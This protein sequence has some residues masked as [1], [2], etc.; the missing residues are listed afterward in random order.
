MAGDFNIRD[1]LWNSSFPYHSSI[2]N[3][4]IIIADSFHLSLLSSINQV[5]TR[6]AD[7]S[8]DANS[9]IDLMFL[10][11]DSSE[12]NNHFIHPKWCLSSDHAPLIIMIPIAEEIINM[13]K[14]TISKDS[15]EDESFIKDV[16]SSTKNLDVLKLLDIPSLEKAVNNLAKDIDNAWTKNSKLT[17]ITKHSKSWWNN[18]CNRNLKRYRS[19]KSLED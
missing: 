17:N 14:R 5:P 3:N 8:N 2:S 12:L 18:N 4:L 19:L 9:V 15:G 13:C 16:I 10:Q 11:C 6:Y 1:S 7:N